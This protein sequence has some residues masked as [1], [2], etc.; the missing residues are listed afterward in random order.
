[1]VPGKQNNSS[2]TILMHKELCQHQ[3]I[4]ILWWKLEH[5]S[6]KSFWKWGKWVIVNWLN[7]I[8]ESLK[9]QWLICS[10]RAIQYRGTFV[11]NSFS[12]MPTNNFVESS[13]WNFD[14]L[15]QPQQHPARDAH[16]TFFM[17]GQWTQNWCHKIKPSIKYFLVEI[18]NRSFSWTARCKSKKYWRNA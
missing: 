8:S 10:L 18:N 7:L 4:F 6:D 15:F 16:D 13:F 5:S 2:H 17:A 11:F 12:E 1:M 3:A 14:S 9:L